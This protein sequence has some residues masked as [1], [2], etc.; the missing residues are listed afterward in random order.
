MRID[1]SR[2][3][4]SSLVRRV[5]CLALG[6]LLLAG[7]GCRVA[8][9]VPTLTVERTHFVRQVTADGVLAAAESTLLSVPPT[10]QRTVRL[11]WLA[12]E[13]SQLA[14][15][16]LVA[17]FD[18]RPLE[19]AIEDN[20]AAITEVEASMDKAR[21]SS[22][23]KIAEVEK[24]L[25][26]STL[27]LEH[28][29][30]YQKLDAQ[31]FSRHDILDSAIDEQL[32]EERRRHAEAARGTLA[33]TSRAE[34]DLLAIDRRRSALELEEAEETLD[35][36]ELRAPHDGVLTLIR[37]WNGE[38]PQVGAEMWRSQEFA[39]IPDLSTMQ[40]E[41]FVLEADAGGLA[42]G[43]RAD[44]V[45]EAYPDR[46]YPA[47][48]ATVD[49]VAKPRVRSSPVQYLGVVLALEDTDTVRMKPGQR[50]RATL[51]LAERDDALVVP[52]QAVERDGEAAF[53]WLAEGAG[54]VRR[55][56]GLGPSSLGHVVIESGLEVGDRIAL[57][58]PE[59]GEASG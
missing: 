29:R 1:T 22:E 16:D 15:G 48:L 57:R 35:A 21:R 19:E 25:E 51:R 5:G 18:P 53:V 47:V 45:I 31:V 8:E 24:T 9:S 7:L 6:P 34:L 49:P 27:E 26:S 4:D 52:R 13:G 28:A 43:Q 2:N 44:V 55:T 14:E 38:T 50:V 30:R 23:G 37:N 17:R 54:F 20:Q 46:V 58:R 33:E 41:V 32:A 36:L 42:P 10:I 56:V 11:A 3:A 39:E 12:P 59:V 40:A